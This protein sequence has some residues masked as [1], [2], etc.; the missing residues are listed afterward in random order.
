MP[1]T[2]EQQTERRK[3]IDRGTNMMDAIAK[4]KGEDDPMFWQMMN[5]VLDQVDEFDRRHGL[6]KFG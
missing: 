4:T 3:I 2:P 1:L 5:L 6:K